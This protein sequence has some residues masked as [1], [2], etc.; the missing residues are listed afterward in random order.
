MFELGAILRLW[1]KVRERGEECV[2]A[3][4]LKTQG[5]SYRLPGA[6]LL[7]TRLGERAGSVS[8]GCLEDDL[9]KRSW[10]LTESGPV[11][12]RYDTTADGEIGTPFGLGCNG[13]IH[14]LLQRVTPEDCRIMDVIGQVL[15]TRQP[16]ILNHVLDVA[17]VG[18]CF[19]EPVEGN[20]I[21]REELR[22]PIQLLLCGA[23]DD[24]A[25]LSR[26]AHYLGWRVVV[27]DGRSHYARPERF[28]SAHSVLV[29]SSEQT[30]EYPHDRW[31]AGVIMT[32]SYRQ[33]AVFLS[34]LI[35]LELPYLGVLGPQK[36]TAQLLEDCGL[37]HD[38]TFDDLHA[39]MGLDI[40]AD[41]PEQVSLAV[42]TEIQATM[43]GR[44]GG[45]LR[46]RAGSIHAPLEARPAEN[47]AQNRSLTCV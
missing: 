8:G 4:V 15:A 3:T 43:N 45:A 35:R 6:R 21:F 29:R 17:R 19:E 14:V 24:A 1:E 28:P 42:I 5:S 41:G 46:L 20:E 27:Y 18:T 32:H 22:P 13:I 12:C 47:T 37:P 34:E 25:S 30:P 10:W 16:A 2:L 31:T 23:G 36:R 40:G 9:T 26:L 38:Q 7:L 33:D 44:S 39:P 11:V